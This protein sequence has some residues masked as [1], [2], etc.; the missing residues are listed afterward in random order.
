MNGRGSRGRFIAASLELTYACSW[1]C[2]FCYNPRHSDRTPLDVVEWTIVLDDLRALGTLH[3][4]LTGG[5]PLLHPQFFEIAR[6]AAERHFAIT[7]FTNGSR[8]DAAMASRI[9]ALNPFVTELTVHGATAAVHNAATSRSG[10]FEDVTAAVGHLLR[11]GARVHLKTVLTSM[12][13]H[14]LESMIALAASLGVPFSVDVNLTP[15][16]D[17]SLDPLRFRASVDG[18]RRAF[19][20]GKSVGQLPRVERSDAK[21]NCALG[22]TTIAIDPEG[23]VY[24]CPQWRSSS[25]GNVR[26]TRLLDLWTTSEV[27]LAASAVA[28]DASRRLASIQPVLEFPFCPA[29]ALER[30]GDPLALSPEFV[31]DAALAAELR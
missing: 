19:A 17:G 8:I 13:E 22:E 31:E 12:N 10:S 7:I 28:R 29:L 21:P 5:E 15:R 25:L 18:R 1:R 26:L 11:A 27:R 9:A 14:E 2:V 23:N 6:A 20:W 4:A 3:V 24:P 30:T 16:D